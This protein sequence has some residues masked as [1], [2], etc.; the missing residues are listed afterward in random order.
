MRSLR[1]ADGLRAIACLM[2][3]FHHLTQKLMFN[4]VDPAVQA[5]GAFFITGAAGVSVFF[6]LSG[7]LLAAPFWEAW[8]NGESHPDLRVY[9]VRRA[10]R[11]MPSFFLNL[12]VCFFLGLTYFPDAPSLIWRYFAGLSFTAGFHWLSFFPAEINGPLWSIG[13]EVV[14]YVLMPLGMVGLFAALGKKR[15]FS[16]AM[17]F[18]VA[19]WVL[20]F[21]ANQ[22]IQSLVHLDNG[23]K[24]WQFG[25]VGGAKFWVPRYNPIGFFG[26]YSL[27]VLAAGLVAWWSR[28]PKAE[29]R[30]RGFEIASLA[31]FGLWL[32]LLASRA[33]Q[34]DFSFNLQDQP[35]YFPAFPALTALLL[36]CLTQSGSVG[37]LFDNPFFRY[38]ARI[39]FGL[40]IWHY[41]VMFGI[42]LVYPSYQY[43]SIGD[44]GVWFG[45]AGVTLAISY[46][47]ATVSWYWLEKPILARA[48]AWRPRP[49]G[50]KFQWSK[51]KTF[52][53]LSL[54]ILVLVPPAVTTALRPTAWAFPTPYFPAHIQQALT[55]QGNGAIRVHIVDGRSK[56][57]SFFVLLYGDGA[58]DDAHV[59]AK[60]KVPAGPDVTVE[61]PDIPY[62][63]YAVMGMHDENDNGTL[64]FVGQIP[65]EGVI[66]ATLPIAAPDFDSQK[67]DF[68]E[69]ALQLEYRVFY[70]Q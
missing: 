57:G 30:R 41:V 45:L 69:P 61:F 67:F 7:F 15:S 2:V 5:V 43:G 20:T 11:I 28:S 65:A 24:G 6:I 14:S 35:Y 52:V 42:T 59:V 32:A 54:A 25:L 55:P 12:F 13:F 8:L 33:G 60:R 31:C 16:R 49:A 27:G 36:A 47:I 38:T 51:F 44:L 3:I 34:D 46:V 56:T 39:S 40:Y 19:I 22:L 48:Q 29:Q 9:A 23:G 58:I 62:R 53:A 26:H 66:S 37:K 18:W 63:Q 50:Q 1:G 17:A 4:A 21:A 64:E 10:G 70:P 68:A